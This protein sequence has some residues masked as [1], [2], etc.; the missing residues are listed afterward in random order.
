[1][2]AE[3]LYCLI[4]IKKEG[5]PL[6][7]GEDAKS[8]SSIRGQTGIPSNNSIPHNNAESKSKKNRICSPAV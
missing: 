4:W 1:M 5:I 7:F 8:I 2:V 3:E 6:A